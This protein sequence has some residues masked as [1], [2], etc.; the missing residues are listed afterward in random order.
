MSENIKIDVPVSAGK[1]EITIE[2]YRGLL[3]AVMQATVRAGIAENDSVNKGAR[4]YDLKEEI[5]ALKKTVEAQGVKLA[6]YE[7]FMDEA[8]VRRF[9]FDL[10]LR[11]EPFGAE[12]DGAE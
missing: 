5:T 6:Q 4:I 8:P 3:E 9:E 7:G 1:V 11:G 2:E 10:Y 12:K